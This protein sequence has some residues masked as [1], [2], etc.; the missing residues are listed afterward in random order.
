[1]KSARPS[2]SFCAKLMP[3]PELRAGT[4]ML[5]VLVI[6]PASACA[7]AA[8][9][10]PGAVARPAAQSAASEVPSPPAPEAEA[11]RELRHDIRTHESRI[12]DIEARDGVYA[13][14]LAEE[15]DDLALAYREDG[16]YEEAAETLQ[17][18]LHIIRVNQGLY[19][20][21]QLAVLDAL[22]DLRGKLKQW[23]EVADAYDFEL[24][25]HRRNFKENDPVLLP[26][27][28]R[29]RSWHINAYRLDTGRSLSEHFYAAQKLYHQAIDIIMEQTG[30]RQAA[31]CFWHR[32]CCED[33]DPDAQAMCAKKV[34]IY[35]GVPLDE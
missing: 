10:D 20:L 9:V 5:V 19:S 27:L 4:L 29:L 32:E 24:W 15:L 34:R 12:R 21:D 3:G 13:G 33:A 8:G 30:D 7:A 25:L 17:R 2:C 1:M 22:I 14:A 23:K 16:Q 11:R 26:I 28:K 31:L 6:V 18:L 35:A